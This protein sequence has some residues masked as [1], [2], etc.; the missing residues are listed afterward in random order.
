[1]STELW[2]NG[3]DRGKLKY[4]G[5]YLPQNYFVHHKCYTLLIIMQ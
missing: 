3:T 1:M 4:W 2:W 5:K